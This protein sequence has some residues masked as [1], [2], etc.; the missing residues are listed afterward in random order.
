M[1]RP[2]NTASIT[3]TG[4]RINSGDGQGLKMFCTILFKGEEKYIG[5]LKITVELVSF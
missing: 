2:I 3:V 4:K 5:V 1:S